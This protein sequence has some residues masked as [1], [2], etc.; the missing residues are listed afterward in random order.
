M[1]AGDAQGTDYDVIVLGGGPAGTHCAGVLADGGR[2]VAIVEDVLLG[3]ECDFYACMPSKT[4]LRPGE[5]LTEARDAPGARERVADDPVEPRGVFGWRDFMVNDYDDSNE[6]GWAESKGIEVIRSRGRL[7]GTGAVD[8][9]GLALAAGDVVIATGS[10]PNT[11]PV[12]GLADLDGLWTNREGT[13]ANEVPRSLLAMGGGPVGVELAQVF[14][15]LGSEVA[16]V[17][18]Q[19]RVLPRSPRPL[20]EALGKAL[21]AD[22]VELRLGEHA[23]AA[24]REGGEY[25]LSFEHGPELRGD[26]MLVATGRSPRVEDLGLES[27]GLDPGKGKVEVDAR[28]SA[29][30]RLWAIGDVTGIW[31]LTYVGK[32][33][34]RVAAA[35]ILGEG[36]EADYSAVPTVI[37][38]HPQAAAVG[39][40]EGEVEARVELASVPRTYTFMREYEDRPDFMTLVSDGARL[41]GAYALGPEAGE[42]LQQAT[43]AIK[44]KLPL[45]LLYDTIQPFPTFSEAFLFALQEL[46]SKVR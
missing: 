14:R 12:P 34:G 27:V 13:G 1:A 7:A 19:D 25:V 17:E 24:W 43:V 37:F 45:D 39:A 16:L 32:Y 20:G 26:R 9:D 40:A 29:G 28:M 5:A 42:W 22:G 10:D 23:S 41:T 36:A 18:G 4:L 3:G 31:P 2:R 11:P 33:Q 8:V 35:N 44:A 15:S 6:V 38:T 46:R 21:E 30:E